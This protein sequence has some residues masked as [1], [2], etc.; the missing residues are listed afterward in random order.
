M[1]FLPSHLAHK[2][3]GPHGAAQ[4]ARGL[5]VRGVVL[6]SYLPGDPDL[7][8]RQRTAGGVTCDVYVY[9]RRHR[10]RLRG[11]P[12]RMASAGLNDHEVWVPRGTTLDLQAGTLTVSPEQS[13]ARASL[14]SDMDGDHVLV[15]FLGGDLNQPIIIGQIPHPQNN[16]HPTYNDG[17][18]ALYKY[19]RWIRGVSVGVKHD[20]NVAVD[21]SAASDGGTAADGTEI[22]APTTAGNLKVTCTGG[23]VSTAAKVS[24][25]STTTSTPE[26][27][28]VGATFLSD[29][30]RNLAAH[31]AYAAQLSAALSE[32]TAALGGFG[33]PT[34]QAVLAVAQI[35][36][37]RADL[38][39]LRGQ[40]TASTTTGPP[41]LSIHLEAD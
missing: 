11:V 29:L 7:T 4:A 38:A 14:A 5:V 23:T 20:G 32:I 35:G 31:D 36:L 19:R 28:M 17:D 22:P 34:P 3:A 1:K 33:I 24:V 30:D 16:R 6:K 15:G 18:T 26:P 9:E 39:V 37:Y 25:V 10:T 13:G 27:V 21:L 2:A 12:I 41:Y 8:D 40:I